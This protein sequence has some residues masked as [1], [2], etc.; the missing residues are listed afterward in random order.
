MESLDKSPSLGLSVLHT[1]PLRSHS[2]RSPSLS[3]LNEVSS[4]SLGARSA[5]PASRI[6]MNLTRLTSLIV[7]GLLFVL[8]L[9]LLAFWLLG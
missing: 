8:L 7:L 5:A 3:A 2:H 4:L 6:A 9:Q 1:R